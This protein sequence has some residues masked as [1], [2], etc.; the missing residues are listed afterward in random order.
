[1]TPVSCLATNQG[2]NPGACRIARLSVP[3][4]S[5]RVTQAKLVTVLRSQSCRRS[6]RRT[7][8][9][10]A[11]LLSHRHLHPQPTFEGTFG[12][13]GLGWPGFMEREHSLM[14]HQALEGPGGQPTHA[15]DAA[16]SSLVHR[17]LGSCGMLQNSASIQQ[18]SNLWCRPVA[19]PAV[20]L[21]SF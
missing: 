12:G 14:C 7:S 5:R 6:Y 18:L 15:T 13:G 3:S 16:H 10:W 1:M 21:T 11:S 4:S 17:A 2:G 9:P 20:C 8:P 19:R